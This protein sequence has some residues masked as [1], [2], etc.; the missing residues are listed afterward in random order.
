MP[1]PKYIIVLSLFESQSKPQ[2]GLLVNREKGNIFFY[3]S[4]NLPLFHI[5][6]PTNKHGGP[7]HLAATAVKPDYSCRSKTSLAMPAAVMAV[8]Q[9]E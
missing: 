2:A 3:L 4:K 7:E 9:P 5:P 6:S 8:G 1:G